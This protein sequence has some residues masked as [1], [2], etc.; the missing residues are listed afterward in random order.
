MLHGRAAEL[1][2][3]ATIIDLALSLTHE[4]GFA[5]AVVVAECRRLVEES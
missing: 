4:G 1:A 5:A 3:T 2:E